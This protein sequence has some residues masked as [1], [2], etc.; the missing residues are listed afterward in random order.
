[1]RFG[2]RR[3]HA[4]TVRVTNDLVLRFLHFAG[5]AQHPAAL[6]DQVGTGEPPYD[7]DDFIRIDRI[8]LFL[9]EEIPDGAL[10]PRDHEAVRF[11]AETLA[12]TAA[13]PHFHAMF[14][15]STGVDLHARR[16]E[17]SVDIRT[18]REIT[19]VGLHRPDLCVLAHAGHSSLAVTSRRHFS[20]LNPSRA[21][22]LS[23]LIGFPVTG[24]S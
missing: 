18:R 13:V 10:V 5:G 15:V 8:D 23:I 3:L 17:A 11:E 4:A 12:D 21:R 20:A 6:R 1:M 14:L 2:S 7:L 24:C 9:V 19:D 16:R 22:L